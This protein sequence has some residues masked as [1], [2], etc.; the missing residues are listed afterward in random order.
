MARRASPGSSDRALA[1]YVH[2]IGRNAG[3]ATPKCTAMTQELFH[4]TSFPNPG[5]PVLAKK[6]GIYFKSSFPW[7]KSASCWDIMHPMT[8]DGYV[9]DRSARPRDLASNLEI[10]DG[11]LNALTDV[12]DIREVFDRV[13]EIAQRVL[14]SLHF[15]IECMVAR[16]GNQVK[17]EKR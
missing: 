14:N 8:S 16:Q 15:Q 1:F 6:A 4:P 17:T 10:L 11:L 9:S 13:F 12:L 2:L 7:S 3:K 5:A